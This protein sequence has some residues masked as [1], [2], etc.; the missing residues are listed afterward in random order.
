LDGDLRLEAVFWR[1][2]R[3]RADVSNLLKLAE[4]ALN[5]IVYRDDSQLVQVSGEVWYDS[6]WPATDLRI[7]RAVRDPSI[8]APLEP[9]EV[10]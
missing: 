7:Y 2:G 5:G 3:R 9:R 6:P 8:R 10:E 4:D 1:K